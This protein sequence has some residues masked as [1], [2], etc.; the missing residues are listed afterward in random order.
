MNRNALRTAIAATLL[1][2]VALPCAAQASD[3]GWDW[4]FTTYVWAS[5]LTVDFG[6]RESTTTFSDIMD[7]RDTSLLFHLEGQG[8]EWGMFADVIYLDLGKERRLDNADVDADL[9]TAIVDLAAVYS[10]GEGRWG[11]FEGF[12]GIRYMGTD[13]SAEVDPDNATLPNRELELDKGFTD[14]LI[15]ARYV[16]PLSDL[17]SVAFRAD[18]SFGD[19]EGSWSA[20]VNTSRRIGRGALLLGYRY[21]ELE[22]QPE[23]STFDLSMYGPQIAYA[24]RW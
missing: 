23:E 21:F 19:S 9:K 5:D 7:A 22:L 2:A 10:P 17:W 4:R 3:E 16:V 18:A 20:S 8:D 11:G 13:F 12:A 24:F 6:D 1:G 15:G 14:F